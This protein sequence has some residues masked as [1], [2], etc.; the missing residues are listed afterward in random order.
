M[1]GDVR[2]SGLAIDS[3]KDV[4]V[5]FDGIPLDKVSIS[6]TINW[7]VLT[8]MAMYIRATVDHQVELGP[9]RSKY[10]EGEGGGGG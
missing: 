4:R 7:N 10:S 3:V 8:V 5:L 6:M 9:E 1:T 2:M